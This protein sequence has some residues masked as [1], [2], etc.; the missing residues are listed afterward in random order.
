MIQGETNVKIAA[1][2]AF[3]DI[4]RYKRAITTTT[5]LLCG[6]AEGGDCVPETVRHVC[7]TAHGVG[8]TQTRQYRFPQKYPFEVLA[9]VLFVLGYFYTHI[10]RKKKR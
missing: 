7:S 6:S 8:A 1:E 3:H 9:Y 10:I 2:M 5:F 4:S